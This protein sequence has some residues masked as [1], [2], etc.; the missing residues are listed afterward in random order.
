MEERDPGRAVRVVLDRG[1]P[2]GNAVLDAL[3][4]DL[5]VAALVAPALVAAGDTAVLVAAA[6]LLERSGEA[7][8]RLGLRHLLE[9]G[10]GHEAPAGARRLV[11]ADG[12][13]ACAPSKISI[14]SPGL[15]WTIAFFHP[16]LR[17]R[18]MP[19]RFGFERTWTMFTPWT[20]TS[21]NSSTACRICV[22]CAS[23]W[24]RKEYLRSSIS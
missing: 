12:H 8:L 10:D 7:L 23:G 11:A 15:S 3:E 19:R 1:D 4:V 13:Y 9:G 5:P 17:P 6:R 20:W 16:G 18:T 2:G 24:T 21:N 14:D 22:L